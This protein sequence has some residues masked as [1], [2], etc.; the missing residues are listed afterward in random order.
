VGSEMCIRDRKWW[1]E[2]PTAQRAENSVH[3]V[4]GRRKTTQGYVLIYKPDHPNTGV[5][6]FVF[7]HR[8]MAEKALGRLLKK[9][10]VVHHINGK[11]DDNRNKNFVICTASFHRWI[12]RRMV[13]LYQEKHFAH[14]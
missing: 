12:E 10:E 14:I 13:E 8:F 2:N 5:K 7:E 11:K 9:G 3:W 1:K 6:R 4:G